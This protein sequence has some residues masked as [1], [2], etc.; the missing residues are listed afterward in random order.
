MRREEYQDMDSSTIV[1]CHSPRRESIAA[2][3]PPIVTDAAEA[4]QSLG[5][6]KHRLTGKQPLY[7]DV[8]VR[9]EESANKRMDNPII[10]EPWKCIKH[11]NSDIPQTF[12]QNQM[13]MLIFGKHGRAGRDG[14]VVVEHHS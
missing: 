8:T 6:F 12:L 5:V 4:G 7:Q 9:V 13:G 3:T 1:N 14:H 11:H 2:Q 10:V